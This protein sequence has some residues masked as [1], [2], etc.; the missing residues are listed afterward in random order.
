MRMS[1]LLTVAEDKIEKDINAHFNELKP[2]AKY[3]SV[4]KLVRFVHLIFHQLRAL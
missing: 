4:I 1:A 2:T 3:W